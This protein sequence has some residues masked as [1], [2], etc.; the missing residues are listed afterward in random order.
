MKKLPDI[1]TP[2][3][4]AGG[5]ALVR[6]DDGQWMGYGLV[7]QQQKGVITIQKQWQGL[8]QDVAFTEQM[9]KS[10]AY[11]LC[12]D[13]KGILHKSLPL[14]S[15]KPLLERI[16]ESVPGVVAK[17]F[18]IQLA[19][20]SGK[21]FA[22]LIRKDLL[23]PV[24][25]QWQTAGFGITGLSLGPF[26]A[27]ILATIVSDSANN[28]P[29]ACQ[30]L[31]IQ[32]GR[33][34]ALYP[35]AQAE[36]TIT[37][38]EDIIGREWTTAY[39]V[40]FQ[41]LLTGNVTPFAESEFI[42]AQQKQWKY[43]KRFETTGKGILIAIFL[44]LLLNFFLFQHFQQAASVLEEQVG[45]QMESS[46]R[47]NV[48]VKNLKEK[49]NFLATSG[50]LSPTHH[51]FFADTLAASLPGGI[52]LTELSI[53]PRNEALSRQEKRSVFTPDV[54]LV[55]GACATPEP[56][57]EWMTILEQASWVSQVSQPGYQYDQQNGVAMFT[58]WI[59]LKPYQT[60]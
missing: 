25:T 23:D 1:L 33:P 45:H 43:R 4:Q 51:S 49:R 22:S 16:K 52:R 10:V 37:I 59:Y 17:D 57:R 12:V 36:A 2:P 11:T 15:G 27:S 47:Q 54:I 40:A 28:L 32:D 7:L 29:T 39:A 14:T 56:L 9:P 48:L 46:E 6:A 41:T 35:L 58:V 44:G 18:Y 60:P 34:Y 19:E 3:R 53:Y 5:I 26:A 20:G 42:S 31:N 24:L 50:W 38:G 8:I 55:K 13:G 30:V 21:D